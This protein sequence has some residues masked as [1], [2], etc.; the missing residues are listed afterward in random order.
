MSWTAAA[1]IR[2]YKVKRGIE[3]AKK[4]NITD[5]D[6]AKAIRDKYAAAFREDTRN[7]KNLR[8]WRW[9]ESVLIGARALSGEWVWV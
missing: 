9:S 8:L 3:L 1:E 6:K 4:A 2:N 7:T 5:V